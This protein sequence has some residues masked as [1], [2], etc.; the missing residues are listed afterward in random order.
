[1]N[2]VA[3]ASIAFTLALTLG[4]PVALADY[5]AVPVVN[6]PTAT[7]QILAKATEIQVNTNLDNV[8]KVEVKVNGKT[9]AAEI[10]SNGTIKVGTL[11]G[12]KDKVQ[13]TIQ[14]D[15]GVS[16]DVKVTKSEDPVSIANVN[17]AVNSSALSQKARAFLDRVASIVKSKGYKNISF[18]GYT[19]PDGS[20]RLNEALSLA[21]ANAVSAYLKSK[22]VKAS[23]SVD[24]QADNNPVADNDTKEG[25]A[26][27][28]RVEIVVS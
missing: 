11:I 24:A 1:M 2:K 9:V 17:F 27:N 8:Q 19:D 15:A 13:V 14:T 3:K 26:L 23:I 7:N 18:I 21:R 25:K 22:G 4:T 16:A 6:A 12:P 20:K 10:G 5:P 28:R